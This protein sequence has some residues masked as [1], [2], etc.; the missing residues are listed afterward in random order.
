MMPPPRFDD[1]TALAP[2]RLAR[3]RRA[4]RELGVTIRAFRRAGGHPV[5]DAQ[6]GGPAPFERYAHYPTD[7]VDDVPRGYAWYYHAHEPGPS[8]PW[9]EH[10]HFHLYVYPHL[11][12]GK[13]APVALPKQGD[14]A[15]DA[16]IVHLFGLCLSEQ[17]APVRLFTINRWASNEHMYAAPDLLAA[18]DR[19]ALGRETPYPLVSRWLGAMVRLLQP[20]ISWL[21]HERDRVLGEAR[22]ADPEGYSEDR[23]LDVVSTLEFD[24]GEVHA[25]LGQ[26]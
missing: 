14:A 8:R 16:G 9:D 25:A 22:K 4:Q 18:I 19:F 11:F 7:D 21:L 12:A 1:L 23:S 24:L 20:Q 6:G 26:A 3:M 17:G 5:R 2:R 13:A 15:R 10:G